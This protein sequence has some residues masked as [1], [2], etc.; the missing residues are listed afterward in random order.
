MILQRLAPFSRSE[1]RTNASEIIVAYRLKLVSIN[2]DD[3]ASSRS[4]PW[5]IYVSS[6]TRTI[7][8]SMKSDRGARFFIAMK[9]YATTDFDRWSLYTRS[10]THSP[11]VISS[12]FLFLCF[13]SAHASTNNSVSSARIPC[14]YYTSRYDANN[15]SSL[16]I[17]RSFR[18]YRSIGAS[19]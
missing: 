17:F 9:M 5:T 3:F 19:C 7:L 12:I 14:P 18:A 2:D 13:Y 4:L 10:V 11:F 6:H 8:T 16:F 1:R 15:F